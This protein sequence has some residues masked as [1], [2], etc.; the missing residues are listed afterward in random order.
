MCS[1]PT[2]L[3]DHVEVELEEAVGGPADDLTV[4]CAWVDRGGKGLRGPSKR[5]RD[6]PGGQHGP[7]PHHWSAP[8][9]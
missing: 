7:T 1:G 4:L 2:L 6:W 3:V 5:G 8:P 9:D